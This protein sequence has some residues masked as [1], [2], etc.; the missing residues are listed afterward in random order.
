MVIVIEVVLN[1]TVAFIDFPTG[2]YR[3]FIGR[4]CGPQVVAICL[5]IK[6][7]TH[8]VT[9]G[10]GRGGGGGSCLA[11][12]RNG[13]TRPQSLHRLLPAAPGKNLLSS[14]GLP[15]QPSPRPRLLRDR[16]AAGRGRRPGKTAFRTAGNN[17]VSCGG[18][19]ALPV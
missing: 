8:S 5:H 16:Q 12:E 10:C 17:G 4:F 11:E 14:C 3:T 9:S 6:V 13:R 2:P 15:L 19:A 1:P 18:A 7:H